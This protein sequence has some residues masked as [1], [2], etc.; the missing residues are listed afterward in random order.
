MVLLR[1]YIEEQQLFEMKQLLRYAFDRP[2]ISID[3]TNKNS[4]LKVMK[5]EYDYQLPW[6]PNYEITAIV[7]WIAFGLVAYLMYRFSGLPSEPLQVLWWRASSWRSSACRH[8]PGFGIENTGSITSNFSGSMSPVWPVLF[9]ATRI[10]GGWAGDS[11][12]TKSTPNWLTT[13]K[14]RFNRVNP[15]QS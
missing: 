9:G 4:S 2:D 13:S 1:G 10:N 12:G 5:D 3:N 14:A 7:V 11:S 15:G 8:R 6:R